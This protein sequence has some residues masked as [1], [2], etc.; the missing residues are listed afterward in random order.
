MVISIFISVGTVLVIAAEAINICIGRG[1]KWPG[2]KAAKT[3]I[4][5]II[6]GKSSQNYVL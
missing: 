5:E 3:V 2:I 1:I 4:L 6:I